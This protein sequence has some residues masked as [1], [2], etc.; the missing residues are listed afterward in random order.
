M[1]EPTTTEKQRVKDAAIEEACSHLG[2]LARDPVSWTD[3]GA[4][5][6]DPKKE[7]R[8]AIAVVKLAVHNL[9]ETPDNLPLITLL[10]NAIP[11]LERTRPAKWS[12]GRSTDLWHERNQLIVETIKLICR[13]YGFDATRSPATKDKYK[14]KH[15]ECGCSI[16]SKALEELEIK[17]AWFEKFGVK[18]PKI[19]LSE[20]TIKHIWDNRNKRPD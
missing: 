10:R 12:R 19:A 14:D 5:T 8:H 20:K 1:R 4:N 13:E 11:A 16:I 3:R 18:K 9:P 6:L 7:R 17:L 2:R 15:H